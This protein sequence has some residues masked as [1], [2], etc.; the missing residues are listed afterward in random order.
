MNFFKSNLK[1]L[2]RLCI[3]NKISSRANSNGSESYTTDLYKKNYIKYTVQSQS[4]ICHD[5]VYDGDERLP[6][7]QERLEEFKDPEDKLI[8]DIGKSVYFSK[9]G[10]YKENAKSI[11]N[12]NKFNKDLEKQA[13]DLKLQVPIEKVEDET[14][15][16]KYFKD[17]VQIAKHYNIY[18]DLFGQ[19]FFRPCLDL[20]VKYQGETEKEV[21]YGNRI[22]AENTVNKPIVSWNNVLQPDKKDNVFHSLMLVNLDGSF[23]ENADQ[24]LLWFVSNISN[25]DI[26]TGKEN[27][28]YAQPFPMRGTG[29]HR[30]AYVL[31]EHNDQIEFNINQEAVD[32]SSFEPRVFNSKEFFSKFS[33]KLTP[34]GLSFFQTEWDLSVRNFFQKVMKTKEP[35]YEFDHGPKFIPKFEKYP[36][37]QAFTWYFQEYTDRKEVNERIMKNYL[38]D[39]NPFEPYQ[40][41]AKYPI[42]D[43]GIVRPRWY[44]YELENERK[45]K[46]EWNLVPFKYSHKNEKKIEFL[47][48]L[49]YQ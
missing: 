12:Q 42:L 30:C 25:N 15:L 49:P 37:G 20:N 36:T 14:K 46:N 47:K 13:R 1:N 10:E 48:N 38:K 33:Q 27:I 29:W 5:Y 18:K 4:A 45:R 28:Q 24:A 8:T 32:G 44:K 26:N 11:V 6:S 7:L 40:E 16:T 35:V 23:Q 9:L 17:T 2:N 31:F 3:N 21:F 34:V 19:G 43:V 39:V 41:G 22:A